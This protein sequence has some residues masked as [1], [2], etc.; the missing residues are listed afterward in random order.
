VT[1]HLHEAV[2]VSH[3]ATVLRDGRVVATRRGRDLDEGTLVRDMVGSVPAALS[4]TAEPARDT[5]GPG[6]PALRL[7]D[8]TGSVL[9]GIS[10]EVRR[11][12]VVAAVGLLGS[13]LEELALIAS[14]RRAPTSGV[15]CLL[16]DDGTVDLASAA[17]SG[18][19]GLVPSERLSH[20]LLGRLSVR[21]NITISRPRE[22]LRGLRISKSAEAAT[23]HR[24]GERLGLVPNDPEIPIS[25]LSGGNQQKAVLARWLHIRPLA[26]VAAEPTQ[27]VD[28]AAKRDLLAQLRSAAS[29]FPVLLVSHEPEEVLPICDR[30]VV[31]RNGSLVTEV[32]REAAGID[33][34]LE[35]FA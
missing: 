13:G 8:V 31:L 34:L 1:H 12:E 19:V 32:P 21:E 10:I 4:P 16:T 35:A 26:I 3:A 7:T 14:G 27:G 29:S 5:A 23:A 2:S 20:A 28:L 18:L 25:L 6:L 30:I 15:A 22:H 17:T 11:G 33:T 24:W 9:K